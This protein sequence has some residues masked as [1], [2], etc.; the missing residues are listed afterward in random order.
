MESV[1]GRFIQIRSI[2][3]HVITNKKGDLFG[4]ALSV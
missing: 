2:D 4:V 1:T 3:Y